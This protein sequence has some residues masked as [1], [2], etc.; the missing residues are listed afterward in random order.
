VYFKQLLDERNGCAS[1][2]IAS[3]ES[4]D[5]AIVDP[6]A[7]L[8]RYES[9]LS[10]RG[11]TLRYVIDTH[12]HADHVSTGPALARVAGARYRLGA[13]VRTSR[14]EPLDDG[15]TIEL[16]KVR[17]EALATPGHSPESACVLVRDAKRG[18]APWILLSGDT[19]FV[20]DVGRPDLHVPREEGAAALH[21]SLF[22]KLARVPDDVALHPAHYGG[23]LCGRYLSPVAAST[24]GFERRHNLGL[25]LASREEFLA[26]ALEALPAAPPDAERVLAA[27][28]G[29]RAAAAQR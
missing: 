8:E 27:N 28:R 12:V 16:G 19:L 23:S 24:M 1:Y 29:E 4:G 18:G 25:S 20:G 15:A 3:R 5:A 14:W 7:D 9:V 21:A 6:S 22:E 10:E 17:L 2:V 13:G 11:F 26:F